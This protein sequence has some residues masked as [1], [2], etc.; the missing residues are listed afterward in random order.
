MLASVADRSR[1]RLGLIELAQQ[2]QD[3]VQRVL[4]ERGPLV[5][6][7]LGVRA[8]LCGKPGCR[9]VRGERHES[10]YLA[11]TD[12]GRVRQVHVPVSEEDMVRK[13]VM[14][15]RRFRQ[16][17]ERLVELA[18]LQ[19]RLVDELGSALLKPYPKDNPLPPASRRG[20]KPKGE[21]RGKR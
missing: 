13:G 19:L 21:R 16:M 14:R 20:P 9:C 18:K 1:L 8:R 11:A 12:G 3:Q 2:Y 6:G 4:A 17:R 15:Y 5:R 7:S 10:T